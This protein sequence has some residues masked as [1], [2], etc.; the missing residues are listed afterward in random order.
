M[1]HK[2][3]LPFSE[4]ATKELLFGDGWFIPEFISTDFVYEFNEA[5][6][7]FAVEFIVSGNEI[8]RE[9]GGIIDKNVVKKGQECGWISPGASVGCHRCQLI[10]CMDKRGRTQRDPKYSL[11]IESASID[12]EASRCCF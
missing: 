9:R 8:G 10:P 1:H 12:L 5:L 6:I 3:H 11:D 4:S 7:G 2:N